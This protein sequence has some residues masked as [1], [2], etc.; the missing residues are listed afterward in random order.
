M[1]DD[2]EVD[3]FYMRQCIAVAKRGSAQRDFPFGAVVVHAGNI[4]SERHNEALDKNE[5]YRHA[6]M[7]A[8]LDAQ[9]TL[10]QEQRISSTLYCTVEPCPMCSFAVQEVGIGRVVFGLRS[11][12]MGGYSKWSILQDRHICEAFPKTFR[13]PPKVV[14]DFLKEDVAACWKEWNSEKWL[15]FETTGIF[16]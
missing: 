10:T 13:G 7:L 6:E 3:K 5:V 4:I 16:G 2:G 12:V 1:F 11:F 8:L 14:P 9:R 15:R